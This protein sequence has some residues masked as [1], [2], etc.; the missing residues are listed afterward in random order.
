MKSSPRANIVVGMAGVQLCAAVSCHSCRTTLK[1]AKTCYIVFL[2]VPKPLV[3]TQDRVPEPFRYTRDI[4]THQST[5]PKIYQNLT[6]PRLSCLFT[7]F[8]WHQQ[9]QSTLAFSH[10]RKIFNNLISSRV[11][12][13][14]T[15]HAA[16]GSFRLQRFLYDPPSTTSNNI[17][18]KK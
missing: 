1:I 8:N 4:N 16:R 6:H 10:F 7:C 2:T 14:L 17:F 15:S 3:L 11:Q 5:H 12:V 18:Q 9:K 13:W